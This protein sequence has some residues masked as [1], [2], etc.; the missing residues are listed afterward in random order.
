MNARN[1]RGPKELPVV[2][3]TALALVFAVSINSPTQ[4]IVSSGSDQAVSTAVVV[5]DDQGVVLAATTNLFVPGTGN[6]GETGSTNPGNQQ[7]IAY[8]ATQ[9]VTSDYNGSLRAGVNGLNDAVNATPPGSSLEIGGFSQGA[10]VVNWWAAQPGAMDGRD[11]TL[12]TVGDPCTARTGILVR[13]PEARAIAGSCAPLPSE[14]TQVVIMQAC[15]PI[16]NFPEKIDLLTVANALAG[17]TYCHG[18]GYTSDQLNRPDIYTYQDGNVTYRVIPAEST[19]P[20]V[21]ALHQNSVFLPGDVEAGI[22]AAVAQSGPGPQGGFDPT[23]VSAVY[24][25]SAVADA[26]PVQD[27]VVQA[28]EALQE[29]WDTHVV[30][31]LAQAAEAWANTVSVPVADDSQW[32]PAPPE[33]VVPTRNVAAV[34]EAVQQYIP[35]PEVAWVASQ[36]EASPL[37]AALNGLPPLPFG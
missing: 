7:V 23:P 9:P 26:P 6:P 15:D 11:V 5:V 36:I 14:V 31:P 17:Y 35:A 20:L 25:V 30:E 8:P 4:P 22:D 21:R 27:P 12:V 32:A 1:R 10:Q 37:G 16:A 34:A 18:T 29:A 19:S 3:I 33:P 28:G 2:V 13:S 24:P